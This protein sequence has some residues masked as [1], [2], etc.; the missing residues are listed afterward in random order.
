MLRNQLAHHL[1][2]Q[3]KVDVDDIENLATL[4]EPINFGKAC[5]K[6]PYLT[7]CSVHLK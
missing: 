7:I 4:P 5:S 2:L 3:A 1:E 6:C